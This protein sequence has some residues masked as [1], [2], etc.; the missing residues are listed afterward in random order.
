MKTF[1]KIHLN[2]NETKNYSNY[3]EYIYIFNTN[4]HI[5]NISNQ[6]DKI[7]L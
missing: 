6:N 7:C 3:N 4:N 2:V 1:I 5:P